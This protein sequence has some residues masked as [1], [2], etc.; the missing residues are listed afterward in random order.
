MQ[1]TAN[2]AKNL[3]KWW[4]LNKRQFPWRATKVP[5]EILVA[6]VLLHRTRAEQ[7]SK[8]Y[9]N[10]L[11]SFPTINCLAKARLPEIQA[12]LGGLGLNWRIESS[13]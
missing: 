10:F 13:S 6:E 7:V 8:V 11:N 3:D 12:L 9:L 4:Q 5:Y 1:E 2:F